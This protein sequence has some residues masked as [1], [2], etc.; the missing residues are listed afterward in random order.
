VHELRGPALAIAVVIVAFTTVL[1][2]VIVV[3]GWTSLSVYGLVKVIGSGSD[4]PNAAGILVAMV[5][6][7]TTLV[8]MLAGLIKVIGKAMESPKRERETPELP[9][10]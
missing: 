7:V 6:I 10:L 5:L 9:G 4:D 3:L 8:A 1:A 2:G